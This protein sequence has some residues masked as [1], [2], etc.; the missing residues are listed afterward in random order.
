MKIIFTVS[1]LF[2]LSDI[3]AQQASYFDPAQ[4]YNRLLIEKGNGTY[5]QISN[6]KVTGTSFLYGEKNIGSIYA[7]N[8]TGDNILLTYDTYTQNVDFSPSATGPVLTKEPGALDS[9]IIKKKP[10]AM[11]DNDILFVYGSIL[12]SKDKVYFQVVARG[13]KVHLYKKYTAELGMVSTNYIQSELRQFNI[14]VEYLYADSTG[15]GL[16]KLKITAKNLVKEFASVKDLS[17][18]INE[19]DLTANRENELIRLFEEMNRD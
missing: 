6:F 1:L 10:D 12:G 4:A 11:L 13:K 17:G 16:K 18:I 5:R 3:V 14:N 15:K 8:E 19:D 7:T 9:F 2:I